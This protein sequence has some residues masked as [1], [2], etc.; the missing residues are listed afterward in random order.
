MQINIFASKFMFYSDISAEIVV[1]SIY[2]VLEWNYKK[3]ANY[4]VYLRKAMVMKYC[5]SRTNWLPITLKHNIKFTLQF[6]KLSAW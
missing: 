6:N 4:F 5:G 2:E 1:R 3:K